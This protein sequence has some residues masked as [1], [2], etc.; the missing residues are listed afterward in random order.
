MPS[1]SG[2]T[3][4]PAARELETAQSLLRAGRVAE[5]EQAFHRALAVDPNASPGAAFPGRRGLRRGAAERRHRFAQPSRASQHGRHRHADGTR[6]RLPVADRL[7][8]SRCGSWSARSSWRKGGTP[9][10]VCCWRT[11]WSWMNGRSWLCCTISGPSWTH[12][13]AATGWTTAARRHA[14]T[15]GRPRNALCG[16]RPT[17]AVRRRAAGL[18]RTTGSGRSRTHRPRAGKLPAGSPRIARGPAPASNFCCVPE[19]STSPLLVVLP[20]P[21]WL[22][23]LLAGVAAAGAELDWCLRFAARSAV[24]SGT[25]RGRR[26]RHA[27]DCLCCVDARRGMAHRSLPAGHAADA[28]RQHAPQLRDALAATPLMCI[29]RHAPD[30]AIIGLPAATH[31]AAKLGRS[32]AGCMAVVGLPG[33][34]AVEVTAGADTH[35]LQAGDDLVDASYAVGYANAALPRPASCIRHVASRTRHGRAA[36]PDRGVHDHRKL[37]YTPAGARLN[38]PAD[39]A[40]GNTPA[41]GRDLAH[42]V[43]WF[44][45]ALEPHSASS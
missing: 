13:T 25:R 3:I 16:R 24:L 14:A 26:Q 36:S 6:H 22:A 10:S 31:T 20:H 42:Y 43:Q 45:H 11:C 12:S 2:S 34:A 23:P 1:D 19:L 28:I 7:D 4:S 5:A 21:E 27:T 35:R 40:M 29:P 32:N 18:A 9:A 37:G 8:A 30:A 39:Q 44:D 17:C 33:S 41:S 38:T 15:A